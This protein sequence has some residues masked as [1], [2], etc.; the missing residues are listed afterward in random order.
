MEINTEAIFVTVSVILFLVGII[1][2]LIGVY[3]YQRKSPMYF[4][5]G[6]DIDA[7]EITDVKAYNRAN[8]IM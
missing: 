3:A 1:F 7:S 5:A 4:Y 8:G 6:S 2:V